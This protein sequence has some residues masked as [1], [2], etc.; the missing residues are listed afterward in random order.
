MNPNK[1][2]T[3]AARIE[4]LRGQLETLEK[5]GDVESA[6][7]AGVVR[8]ELEALTSTDTDDSTRSP[9]RRRPH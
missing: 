5:R 4:M 3:I 8:A 9:P 7:Q 1:A 2:E 6:R